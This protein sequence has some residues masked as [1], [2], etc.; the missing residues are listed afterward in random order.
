MLYLKQDITNTVYSNLLDRGYNIGTSIGSNLVLNPDFTELG[1]EEIT[2][3]DFATDSD[4]GLGT[5]WSISGG[6]ANFTYSTPS[7]LTQDLNV[8]SGLRYLIEYEIVSNS[9]VSLKG[10][11]NS[12]FN[13]LHSRAS[14]KFNI[15]CEAAVS[16]KK[17]TDTPFTF[18]SE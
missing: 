15:V 3:G 7:S 18:T 13:N 10:G 8:T 6:S 14:T 1:S 4:W 12:F 2:N 16:T 5:G 17:F 9:G 11:G